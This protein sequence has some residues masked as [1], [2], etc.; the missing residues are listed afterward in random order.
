MNEERNELNSPSGSVRE[1]KKEL[2]H[3]VAKYERDFSDDS[4]DYLIFALS[5]LQDARKREAQSH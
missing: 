4:I 3:A 5:E 1:A 2:R